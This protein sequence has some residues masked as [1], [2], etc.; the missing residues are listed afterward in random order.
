MGQI[1]SFHPQ[2]TDE[3]FY[4]VEDEGGGAIW[5]GV[6][7]HTAIQFWRKYPNARIFVSSWSGEGED[8]HPT[9]VPIELTQILKALVSEV[10]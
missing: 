1:V 10:K 3:I 2:N 9:G 5:G 7:A 8:V 4:T 6:G